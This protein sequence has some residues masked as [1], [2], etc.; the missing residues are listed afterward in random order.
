MSE[1]LTLR[2]APAVDLN[3]RVASLT[4]TANGIEAVLSTG[5][6]VQRSGFVE[7]LATWGALPER[8][9]LLDSHRR[10]SVDSILGY[11]DN[12]R[13]DNGTIRGTVHISES[14]GDIRQKVADGSISGVSIGFTGTWREATEGSQRFRI[15]E[16]ITLREA[17]LVVIG[18]D[19]GARLRTL[20]AAVGVP[21]SFVS[22]LATRNLPE[23][24]QR[25]LIIRQAAGVQPRI[26][27]RTPVAVS[28][29][30]RSDLISRMADG[31]LS[32]IN[33]QHTPTV[34]RE[35]SYFSIPDLARRYLSEH[36]LS[37]FGSSADIVQRALGGL[38]TTSDFPALFQETF[39]QSLLELRSI[40]SPVAQLFRRAT[41]ADFRSRHILEMTDGPA[42]LKVDEHGEIK[43]GT[44]TGKELAAYKIDSYGRIF[45]LTFQTLVNDD[46]NV[47]SDLSSMMIRGARTWFSSLL[48]DIILA[49]PKLLDNKPL[50]DPAHKN[51]S[52]TPAA[53]SEASLAEGRTAMRLQTDASGNPIN[54]T[55][56]FILAPAAL[57]TT[58][59]ALLATLYPQVPADAVTSAQGLTPLIEPRLDAKG[60]NKAWYL[61]A[62]PAYAPVFEYSELQGYQ[63]PRTETRWGFNVLG[64]EI[65]VVW[66]VGG[67]PIDSRGAWKNPGA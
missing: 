3:T 25:T 62:D 8:I 45:G 24:E 56:R 17:S 67:G 58:I 54:A 44:V 43:S 2:D 14:R 64:M 27:T 12:L 11:V 20:A 50:F 38:H 22:E 31:L 4:P 21:E 65:R 48:I 1:V 19:S 47:F 6:D 66:H 63:G 23:E 16:G 33:P 60:Q 53:P 41:A 61:F 5:C 26:D 37:T 13:N 39:N 35:F 46:L 18:A 34:G 57:E 10:D 32:R 9:P 29:D 51:L 30:S 42:L 7:R 36:G 40:P 49:N 28:R 59:D 55:P 15:A 52:P